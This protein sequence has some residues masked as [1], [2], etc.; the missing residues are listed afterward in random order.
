MTAAVQYKLQ[1]SFNTKKHKMAIKKNHLRNYL[2][3]Y[4]EP[5]I[6]SLGPLIATKLSNTKPFNHCLI[7]PAYNESH[8]FVNALLSK[9]DSA[10]W[11]HTLI[12]IIVNQPDDDKDIAPNARFWEEIQKQYPRNTLN[13]QVHSSIQ[14]RAFKLDHKDSCSTIILLDFFTENRRLDRKKGVGLARKIGCDLACFLAQQKTLV[15]DWLHTSDADTSLPD[16]YFKQTSTHIQEDTSAAIYDFAHLGEANKITEST[17]LY[18]E[19]I[20]YY[21]D[22]L[23][24]AN[25]PY[26][27]HTLGS[28]IAIR[29]RPYTVVRGFTKRAGGEDFYCLNKLA[30]V[31]TIQQ[32]KGDKLIIATRPSDR[33]PFGT[34]PAVKQILEKGESQTTLLSYNPQVFFELK[35]LLLSFEDLFNYKHD[36]D[37]WLTQQ[38]KETRN[39]L[40]HLH[41]NQLFDHIMLQINDR[42]LCINHIHQWFDAF[43]TLRFIHLLESDYPKISLQKA[44]NQLA[45]G[46]TQ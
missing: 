11:E 7:I 23:R 35:N 29:I 28:C 14:E 26:A 9:L 42:Q 19:S 3:H 10:K 46:F 20:N 8:Q 5:S 25:S 43:K 32:L 39:A 33:V 6:D 36:T 45:A 41:I 30:K 22:G 40:Q 1:S 37:A 44:K 24:Y 13:K 4:A 31:G 12:I 27:Y 34:G 17:Q 38:S 15:T 2:Q 16:N 21:V 18:E